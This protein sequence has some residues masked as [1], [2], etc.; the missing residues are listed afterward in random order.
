MKN[1]LLIFSFVSLL[2]CKDKSNDY[3]L[4]ENVG[5]SDYYINPILL[6][7]TNV[8]KD[9]SF[10][11]KYQLENKLFDKLSD[12]ISLINKTAKTEISTE[13]GSFRTTIVRGDSIVVVHW[14]N[15]INSVK[16]FQIIIYV[17]LL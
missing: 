11:Y 14:T 10:T 8:I 17:I 15:R 5:A 7:K 16:L 2:V 9:E 1:L 12:T 6:C 13:Y 3:I 4:I